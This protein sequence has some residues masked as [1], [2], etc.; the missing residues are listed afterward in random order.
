MSRSMGITKTVVLLFVLSGILTGCPSSPNPVTAGGT[1]TTPAVL[2]IDVPI[3]DLCTATGQGHQCKPADGAWVEATGL[4]PEMPPPGPDSIADRYLLRY[5]DG[6]TTPACLSTAVSADPS[7]RAYVNQLSPIPGQDYISSP[8]EI[9]AAV[10]RSLAQDSA[11]GVAVKFGAHLPANAAVSFESSFEHLLEA[12]L[13]S[14]LSSSGNVR[15]AR[16]AIDA[17]NLR[18][19]GMAARFPSLKN[20]AGKTVTIGVAGFILDNVQ[21]SLGSIS[22][23][24]VQSALEAALKAAA[25][26]I[27][28]SQVATIT[29]SVSAQV[30][31]KLQ[32]SY[33]SEVSSQYSQAGSMFFP[34]WKKEIT[35][36]GS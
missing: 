18:Q 33:T 7:L 28:L 2:P 13:Q 35:L 22:Q 15:F 34:L 29:A 17:V 4:L 11:I 9:R 23:D 27:D 24:D 30:Q 31:Q 5:T 10:A 32:Q 20:C 8:A 6:G 3:S 14:S 26:Q 1:T 19:P 21:L 12:K 25:P 36:L 16:A